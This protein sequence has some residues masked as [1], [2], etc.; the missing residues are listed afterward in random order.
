M[1]Y[2]QDAHKAAGCIFCEQPELG[3]D[4]KAY[5]L[6]RGPEAF[7][8]LNA[9]P[10]NPGHLM[11]APSRHVSE[12][13]ELTEDEAVDCHRLLARAV[14]AIKEEADPDG[15]NVGMNL[16]RVAGAGIPGHVHWHLVPRWNGDTNFMPIVGETRVLPELLGET[17]AKL[18]QRF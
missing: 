15:F 18:R 16:G 13:E 6:A 17:Y 12:L 2:I 8:I 7:V 1:E 3:D 5:I 10:Y 14:R 4:E 11:V 9:F